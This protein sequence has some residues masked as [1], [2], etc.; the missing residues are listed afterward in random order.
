MSPT[1]SH[2]FGLIAQDALVGLFSGAILAGFYSRSAVQEFN[3]ERPPNAPTLDGCI[4]PDV[5][6]YVICTVIIFCCELFGE[7][8]CAPKRWD[9]TEKYSKGK[10]PNKKLRVFSGA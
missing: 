3:Q 1:G 2:E 10:K 7:M 6:S 5:C 8:L 4:Q 9:L